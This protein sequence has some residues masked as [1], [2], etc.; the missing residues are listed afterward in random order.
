MRY[1]IHDPKSGR[2][3]VNGCG[4][5][6]YDHNQATCFTCYETAAR[7]AKSLKG[8]VEAL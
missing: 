2:W 4:F 1:Y 5:H 3:Y 7:L 8:F 6:T